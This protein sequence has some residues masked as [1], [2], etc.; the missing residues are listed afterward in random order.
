MRSP[1]CG[2]CQGTGGAEGDRSPDHVIANDALSQ[3]SYGPVPV[4][5]RGG[6]TPRGSGPLS[7][8][9]APMKEQISLIRDQRVTG[10]AAVVVGIAVV[11]DDGPYLASHAAAC[12]RYVS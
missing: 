11:E 2:H 12:A 4:R 10:T 5:V 1:E 8:E 7:E 3:L 6:F 9:A